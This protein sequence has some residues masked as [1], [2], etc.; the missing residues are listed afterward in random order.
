M[1]AHHTVMLPLRL[2]THPFPPYSLPHMV[3]ITQPEATWQQKKKNKKTTVSL[4]ANGSM[5]GKLSTSTLLSQ[6]NEP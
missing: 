4:G 5:L 2:K 6:N 3:G 1:A